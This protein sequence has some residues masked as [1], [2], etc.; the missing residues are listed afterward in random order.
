MNKG[1]LVSHQIQTGVPP[2]EDSKFEHLWAIVGFLFMDRP[3]SPLGGRP[4]RHPFKEIFRG[5]CWILD[6]GAQWRALRRAFPP[7]STCHYWFQKWSQEGLFDVLHTLLVG[8]ARGEDTPIDDG[9][10]DAMFV[11]S[12]GATEAIGKTKVGKGSKMMAL[13]DEEGFSISLAV[14]SATPH[15]SRLVTDTLAMK[16]TSENPK[17]ITGDKAYDSDPLDEELA[18]QGVEMIAPH[19]RN[20]KKPATQNE[21]KLAEKYPKRH[22]VEN[23]FAYFQ[24]SRRVLV[25]YER[26]VMNYIGFALIKASCVI[27]QKLGLFKSTHK[28]EVFG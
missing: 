24:W 13:V 23:F 12:K 6:T 10:I 9:F 25:R 18:K 11:R 2:M 22:F 20:R 15:E 5:I 21:S 27:I 8:L 3:K 4:F 14:M 26:N 19:K 1:T 7:R 16:A 28:V 17:H